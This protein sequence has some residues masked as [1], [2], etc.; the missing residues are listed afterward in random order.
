MDWWMWIPI[1]VGGLYG[2]ANI[3][4]AITPS[5]K[6]DEAL[7]RAEEAAKALIPKLLA[8]AEQVAF[9]RRGALKIPGK[10]P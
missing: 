5:K 6:D 10:K 2:V 3:V 8:F 4:V 9:L 7:A 1:G